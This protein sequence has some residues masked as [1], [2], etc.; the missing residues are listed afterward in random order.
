MVHAGYLFG[1][2]AGRGAETALLPPK[3]RHLGADEASVRALYPLAW[4]KF[5]VVSP[6]DLGDGALLNLYS[7]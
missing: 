6:S 4:Q 7:R 2:D 1:A 5:V 3:E